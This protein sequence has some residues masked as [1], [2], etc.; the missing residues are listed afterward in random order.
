MTALKV[1]LLILLV[2]WMISLVRV[3]GVTEYSEEGTVV[4]LRVGLF[5]F[6]LYPV[7]E[8]KEKPKREKKRA[9]KPKEPPV[10]EAVTEKT[11]GTLSLIRSFLPLV[12][13][14]AGRLRRKI[15]I[16]E[17][18]LHLTWATADP[19]MTAMGFGAGNAALGMI[20]PL[21]DHNFNIRKRDVGVAADFD[22]TEPILYLR[23]A[24]SMT[25]GQGVA[26]GLIYGIKAL[27]IYIQ[28]RPIRQKVRKGTSTEG[29]SA[30][31]ARR[32]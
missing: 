29:N 24:F 9:T 17:L 3:G 26:F 15:R 18:V 31:E 5:R 20:W 27:S 11:G 22:R 13:E 10:E 21:L 2:L 25:I 23:A 12:C 6:M 28:N 4:K 1:L 32:V 7:K 16:D 8:K 14:A 19:A 30:N